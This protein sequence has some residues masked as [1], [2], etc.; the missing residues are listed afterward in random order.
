MPASGVVSFLAT[1]LRLQRFIGGRGASADQ[2]KTQ[3]ISLNCGVTHSP[4]KIEYNC[5]YFMMSFRKH[6]G[7]KKFGKNDFHTLQGSMFQRPL[8]N[9]S[10]LKITAL[11][12]ESQPMSIAV[13]MEPK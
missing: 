3:T 4:G 6:I 11:I 1:V 7:E 13:H 8:P 5:R 9:T 10:S 12:V 2:K